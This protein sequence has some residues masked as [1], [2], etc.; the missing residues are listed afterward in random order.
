MKAAAGEGGYTSSAK[1]FFLSCIGEIESGD[2]ADEVGSDLVRELAVHGSRWRRWRETKL[3]NWLTNSF[4]I[5]HVVI[6]PL[7]FVQLF[8]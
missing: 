6:L 7:I 4:I 1:K 3:R 8:C 5:L 2:K